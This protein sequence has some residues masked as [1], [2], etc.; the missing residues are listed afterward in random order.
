MKMVFARQ[1]LTSTQDKGQIPIEIFEK[2][3]SN[4]FNAVMTKFMYVF[5]KSRIHHHPMCIGGNDFGECYDR[6]AHTPASIALQSWGVPCPAIKVLL[7]AMQTMRFFLWMGYGEFTDSYGGTY[8]DRTL[9]FGQGNSAAGPGVL[10]LSAHIVNAYIRDGHGAHLQTSFTDCLFVLASVIYVD[11]T[12]LPNVTDLVMATPR[13][14]IDHTQKSTNAWG[15]LAIA[16]GTA[17]K[18]KKCFTYFMVYRFTNDRASMGSTSQLLPPTFLIPQIEG[19]PLPLHLTV[20]LPDGISA[21]IPSLPV[22]TA[23]LMLGIWFGPYSRGTIHILD[24]Y[25]KGHDWAD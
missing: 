10:A 12:D 13:E 4:C 17:L 3:G 23:S 24:M 7:L 2:K 1:M 8:E 18:P 22:T 5:D 11:D 16:A 20:P 14:L 15:G 25:R 9:E 6:V 19:P 21:P